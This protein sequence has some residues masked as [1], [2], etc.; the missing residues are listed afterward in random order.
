MEPTG[1][2]GDGRRSANQRGSTPR[3]RSSVWLLPVLIA[4]L[5][6]SPRSAPLAP[7]PAKP[8]S[9]LVPL[10][11]VVATPTVLPPDRSLHLAGNVAALGAWRPDAVKLARGEDGKWRV[12]VAVERDAP[13]EFKFTLGSW[14]EVEMAANGADIANRRHLAHDEATL[15]LVV[16]RFA[17]ASATTPATL[18]TPPASTVLDPARLRHHAGFGPKSGLPARPIHVWLPLEY[19]RDTTAR[20]PVLYL[21]DGQNCFD[22]ATA[23]AGREWQVDETCDRLVAAGVIPP[24]IVVA[25]ENSAER[26]GEYSPTAVA[27]HPGSGRAAAHAR[28]LLDEVKPFVDATYRTRP[29]RAATAVGGSSLG[30]L[31]SLWLVHEHPETFAAAAALSPAL[32]WDERWIHR[33]FTEQPPEPL[34]RIW[35]DMGTREWGDATPEQARRTDEWLADLAAFAEVLASNGL[36]AGVGFAART[37]EGAIHDES[38]WAARF[39]DV[40]RFL[41]A[42][43]P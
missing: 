29:E 16:A 4:V 42:A 20:F 38:A 31:V 24:R 27:R 28:L 32:G 2:E 17:V 10:H 30:G 37:F 21:H 36:A 19:A 23:F 22:A 13:L 39:E 12:D 43:P 25:I 7:S 18:P 35:L 15:E 3:E 41:F 26:I 5:A 40:L 1:S 34:A 9:A 8:E 11:F 14:I 33:C 6:C